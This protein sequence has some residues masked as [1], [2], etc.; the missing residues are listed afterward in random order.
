MES[1]IHH[2]TTISCY[3]FIDSVYMPATEHLKFN[4]RRR[5]WR[6]YL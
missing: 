5:T 6:A 2:A 1:T 3:P 4:R